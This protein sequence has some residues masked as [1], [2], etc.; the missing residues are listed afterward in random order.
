MSK[1]LVLKNEASP[2]GAGNSML[3]DLFG[4]AIGSLT[5]AQVRQRAEKLGLTEPEREK[6]STAQKRARML[7]NL[8]GA[9]RGLG[10]LGQGYLR[11]RLRP[12]ESLMQGV[13]GAQ[14][15]SATAEP[16]LTR[17]ALSNIEAA[18][19]A[20]E[21]EDGFGR[22]A[23]KPPVE[24]ML[25]PQTPAETRH[26][27]GVGV[28]ER[29][30]PGSEIDELLQY[31]P[32]SRPV[33]EE[34]QMTFSP[35]ITG[36]LPSL[37]QPTVEATP[38]MTSKEVGVLSQRPT[39]NLAEPTVTPQQMR[40]LLDEYDKSNFQDKKD[41]AQQNQPDLTGGASGSTIMGG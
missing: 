41:Q 38:T 23:V 17:R 21:Q 33:V 39:A 12:F 3:S 16:V 37:S 13:Q 5:G 2:V 25:R 36:G 19:E 1:I 35:E 22:V 34:S 18:R 15:A 24:E 28:R 26:F 14:M 11:G 29:P 40:T 7:A 27:K 20:Q 10:Y 8:Y 32:S 30:M 4:G 31:Y 9:G 6:F